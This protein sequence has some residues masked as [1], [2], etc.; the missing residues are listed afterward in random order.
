MLNENHQCHRISRYRLAFKLLSIFMFYVNHF[1]NWFP[2]YKNTGSNS[3]VD[4]CLY[5]LKQ[6][7]THHPIVQVCDATT[8]QY[9]IPQLVS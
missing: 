2:S 6:K 4:K 1:A 7:I 5:T 9:K 8:A 3:K